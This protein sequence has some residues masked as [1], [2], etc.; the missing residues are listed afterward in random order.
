MITLALHVDYIKVRSVE[1][2]IEQAEELSAEMK[3][4]QMEEALVPLIAVEEGDTEAVAESMANL[5]EEHARKVNT[6]NLLLYPYVHLTEKPSN[7]TI[8]FELTKKLEQLML[9]KGFAVKRAPFGWYKSFE[10]RVKGHPLSELSKRLSEKDLKEGGDIISQSIV[11]ESQTKSEFFIMTPDGKLT[12]VKDFD[13]SRH[14][15][16][17][18]F[19]NYEI[20]K[21]RVYEREPEHMVLMREHEL[22]QPEPGS[23]VG[24]LRWLPKGRLIKKLLERHI[25]DVCLREGAVEVETPLMYDFQHPALEKY[26]NRFPARQYIVTSDKRKFFLRFAAC[27]GQFLIASSSTFSYKSL[28]LRIFE[29]TRYSFRRE[30]SGEVAGLRRL[31]A[32]SMP[33]M[34]TLTADLE[35]AKQDFYKQMELSQAVMSDIECEYETAFRILREWYEEN[36]DWYAKIAK[37]IGKPMLVEM[38]DR[39]YAYF[40]TKF[41]FN[42]IDSLD[43]CTALS[44][45]QIDVENAERFDIS[46]VDRDGTKKRPYILHA[47]ISGAVERQVY[48]ILEKQGMI[49]TKGG[50]PQYPLWLAPTQVRVIPVSED[51][52]DYARALVHNMKGKVRADLDD[53]NESLGKRIREAEKE[54]V[55]YIVVVGRDEAAKGIITVRKRGDKSQYTVSPEELI[56][57]ITEKTARYPFEELSLP[58][59]LSR[60]FSFI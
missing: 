47:S 57:E 59:E 55:P 7:P 53:R 16:L 5:I 26:L 27:F 42:V 21:S 23:D 49:R 8:A 30:Q 58:R 4:L 32:F 24:N 22:V 6:N 50:V 29:L 41:E 33:D 43:K 28:P 17:Q 56:T 13:F 10:L 38:F 45:V 20:K 31:R 34:H 18:I 35:Q 51:Q 39:R 25:T 44:T 54:W 19:A 37:K 2:A 3:N 9:G 52:L 40:I 36:K 60:R 15:N 11:Q 14:R 46:Y 48:A 1:K 12:P